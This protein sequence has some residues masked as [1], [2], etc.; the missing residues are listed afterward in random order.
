M[1]A[2]TPLV[3]AIPMLTGTVIQSSDQVRVPAAWY[4]AARAVNDASAPGKA[5][6]LPLDDFYQV[7]TTWGFYGADSLPT[8][9]FTRPTV[10]SNPQGYIGSPGSF[11]EL[12]ATVEH[13][14]VGADSAGVVSTLRALGVS[15]IVVRKD[16]DF[17][18]TIRA[19]K[20]ADPATLIHGLSAVASMRRIASTKVADVYEFTGGTG[21]VAALGGLVAA[22]ATNDAHLAALVSGAPSGTTL[23]TNRAAGRLVNGQAASVELGRPRPSSRRPPA[24]GSTH[25]EHPRFRCSGCKPA[26]P[27]SNCSTPTRSQSAVANSRLGERYP[28]PASGAP[29]P[30]TSAG[31]SS[32]SAPGVPTRGSRRGPSCGRSRR[33]PPHHSRSGARVNDCNHYDDAGAAFTALHSTVVHSAGD[34]L[35]QLRVRRHSAC[36]HAHLPRS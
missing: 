6:V 11:D 25:V 12:A 21:P 1:L 35:V 33:E 10:T 36:V 4:R 31:P 19:V 28:S 13:G 32:M 23:V 5:L 24:T 8:R 16:I 9:L 15:E 7:P 3:F 34:A 27:A 26:R 20:M 30:S 2:L 14:L 22:P 29:S 17:E 18:S